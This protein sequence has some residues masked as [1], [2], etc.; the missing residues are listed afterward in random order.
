MNILR[1]SFQHRAG[2]NKRVNSS[3]MEMLNEFPVDELHQE[4]GSYY[5]SIAGIFYHILIS[6]INLM[7][8]FRLFDNS[9]A[10]LNEPRFQPEG[11]RWVNYEIKDWDAW[12]V[13]RTHLD[14]LII[15]WIDS[16][17]SELY[18]KECE[19]FD[20]RNAAR[21][22]EL[23]ILID[24]MFNHQTHHRGQ[25][26]QIMDTLDVDHDFSGLLG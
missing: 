12:I 15:K 14:D 25:F 17:D 21:K 2:Y 1:K 19:F 6:D 11:S 9:S 4:R 5:R 20:S 3:I 8:R 26:S 16:L 10:I 18:S 24:H 22:N 23:W 7:R 13:E